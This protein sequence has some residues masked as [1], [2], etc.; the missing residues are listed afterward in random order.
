VGDG[1]RS[2][3]TSSERAENNIIRNTV[4][5]NIEG[6]DVNVVDYTT[7]L[8]LLNVTY[9]IANES[10][11]AT[12]TELR[13]QWYYKV[14]VNDTA[15]DDV[16][17]ANVSVY[18]VSGNFEDNLTTNGSGWTGLGVLTEYSNRNGVRTY[19]NNYTIYARNSSY[20]TGIHSYNLTFEGG[21]IY[22]DVFTLSPNAA[23]DNPSVVIN[24]TSG[25]NKTNEDLICYSN[26]TH[27][28]GD[29]LNVSVVW[30]KENAAD[31]SVEYDDD[32]GSGVLFSAVLNSGNTSK[33]D[34]WSCGFRIYDGNVYSDWV[35][36]SKLIILN[37]LPTV[38]LSEPAHGNVTIDRNPNFTW[39]GS[40]ADG[41][42]LEYEI[43]ISCYYGAGGTCIAGNRYISKATLGQ[44]ESY[45]PTSYLEYLSDNNYYYNWSVRVWDG[46]NW[47]SWTTERNISIQSEVSTSLPTAEVYFG[48]MNISDTANTTDDTPSPMIIKN[49][50][51]VFL[52]VSINF[53]DMFDSESN[54]SDYFK[55]KIRN[56]TDGC[57]AE[58]DTIQTWTQSPKVTTFAIH[59][60]NFT[61]G[62]QSKCDNVS[63]DM[64]VEVP[65]DESPGNKSSLVTFISSLGEP[66][67][68]AD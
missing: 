19:Y 29:S 18:N 49:D 42:S 59:Q 64:L 34:N 5:Q 31:F 27:P 63:I 66:G 26:I 46:D 15:G 68:G 22:D 30:Y 39:S 56:L 43:N 1:I 55:F 67:F 14:Y 21:N 7:N 48:Y 51:N 37:S 20:A 16:V 28:D 38:T 17:N 61:S 32:Y 11:G 36:S 23:P 24:S 40:D 6:Y 41:E 44:A 53:T 57:F 35:N 2:D 10:V 4:I 9:N 12:S 3:C 47:S 33:G 13:R 62:Y 8:T 52:N 50:G 54:P 45:S 25:G 58:Q 65:G 60:L